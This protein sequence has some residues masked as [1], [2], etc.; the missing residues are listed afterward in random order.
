LS[1]PVLDGG[2]R[3]WSTSGTLMAM[4]WPSRQPTGS[5]CSSTISPDSQVITMDDSNTKAVLTLADDDSVYTGWVSTTVSYQQ[6]DT[7]PNQPDQVAAYQDQIVWLALPLAR[8]GS[9]DASIE[10]SADYDGGNYTWTLVRS[11]Q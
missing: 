3:T 6:T 8:R 9:L 7:C 10:G 5:E 11:E 1:S 2:F 4:R